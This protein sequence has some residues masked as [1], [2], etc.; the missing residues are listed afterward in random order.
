MSNPARFD[1]V[2]YAVLGMFRET[3]ESVGDIYLEPKTSLLET[4]DTV[5]AEMAS[6]PVSATCATL[7]AQVE[8]V[9]YYMDVMEHYILGQEPDNVDW[10]QAWDTV[11]IITPEAWDES[12]ARLKA[13]Y[14]RIVAHVIAMKDWEQGNSLMAVMVVVVHTA[15]HLGNIRQ[16]LC[17]LGVQS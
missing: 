9:R 5:S 10:R 14:D 13:S 2:K 17:T 3:V 7:A 4:L 11:S 8:H 12:R 16:S 15:Y 1:D 6:I